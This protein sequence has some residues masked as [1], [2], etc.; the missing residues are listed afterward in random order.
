MNVTHYF[1]PQCQ[2]KKPKREKEKMK[3]TETFFCFQQV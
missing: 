3:K 1:H 2:G